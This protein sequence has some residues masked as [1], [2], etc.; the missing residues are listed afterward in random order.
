MVERAGFENRCTRKGTQGSNPCLSA[1][2]PAS[3]AGK[4]PPGR[5]RFVGGRIA[6]TT[7]FYS[8]RL[9]TTVS[10]DVT[11]SKAALTSMDLDESPL[12]EELRRRGEV[13]R[14]DTEASEGAR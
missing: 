4:P 13:L 9:R 14:A 1:I 3:E 5:A 6:P 2:K 7:A 8:V 12:W 10:R 11:L